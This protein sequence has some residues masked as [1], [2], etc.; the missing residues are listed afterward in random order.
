MIVSMGKEFSNIREVELAGLSRLSSP[1]EVE[2]ALPIH[3]I[4]QV[5]TLV[6]SSGI[7]TGGY[8]LLK[9]W[10]DA[11]NGRKL[12]LKVGDI[13]VEATQMAEEERG[14]IASS[15]TASSSVL[16]GLAVFAHKHALALAHASRGG[17]CKR[18][19]PYPRSGAE[20]A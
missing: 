10:I 8:N 16:N 1:V 11:K 18:W 3:D 2:E 14:R 7:P 4:T 5:L 19:V 13:E 20:G 9:S 12:K 15:C 6:A 17:K